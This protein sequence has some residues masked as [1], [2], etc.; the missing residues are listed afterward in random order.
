M[1]VHQLATPSQYVRL[2]QDDSQEVDVLFKELL[3][4]VTSF[5]RDPQAFEAL[6][7]GPLIQLLESRDEGSTVRAWVP[8]CA[9]GEE[10]LSVAIMLRECAAKL[11]KHFDFHLFGTDLDSEAI[12][13]ARA[14]LYPASIAA[15]VS[16]ARLERYFHREDAGYRVRREIRDMVVFAPQN[17]ISDPPFTRLDVISCR[18]LLIYLD[19]DVQQRVMANFHYA[20]NPGGILFLGTSESI[21]K[22]ADG[23]ETVDVKWKIFRR[24]QNGP[25]A[26]A[27]AHALFGGARENV[28]SPVDLTTPKS[29]KDLRLSKLLE[30]A[31]LDQLCPASVVVNER[32]EILQVHGRTGAYLELPRGQAE[33]SVIDMAREGLA[34]ELAGALRAAAKENKNVVR[35]NIRVK[36]NGGESLVN[37]SVNR[38]LDPKPIRGLLIVA[39]H[40][41]GPVTAKAGSGVKARGGAE[42]DLARQLRQMK[43]THQTVLHELETT[44]EELKGANEELQSTNEELQSLNEELETSKE[45]MQS[46][47]EE[48]TTVNTELQSKIDDLSQVNDDMQNLLNSTEIAT[49][50]LDNDLNIKRFT[51]QA[52]NV[53]AV[54]DLDVGRPMSELATKLKRGNLLHECREV[55]RTLVYWEAEVEANDGTWYLARIVPYRTSKNVIDG[56]VVTFVKIDTLREAK[57]AEA[58]ARDNLSSIVETVREPLLVL[59]DSLRVIFCNRSYYHTFQT[60]AKQTQGKLI[61][62]LGTSQWDIAPLRKLLEEILPRDE[63]IDAFR[64]EAEFPKIGRRAFVLNARRLK[65]EPGLPPMILLGME[66]A[67]SEG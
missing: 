1:D 61:Y 14:G 62:E 29:G 66:E 55:L 16:P 4:R 58:L 13:A 17:V 38:I 65:R 7:A 6:A 9:R 19:D 44:N 22:F 8:G 33:L 18:N 28:D 45:E 23:F 31:L 10:A 42:S 56:L 41:A 50:F 53:V 43:D 48:L 59:D 39:F 51:E 37:V 34:H 12:D 40:P 27:R 2:L 46:L 20:L 36:T 52:R 35:D 21:G 47:N 57:K 5:F 63:A 32:G 25:A 49:V 54:R 67:G 15:D 26:H 11:G 24:L 3:I 64:V 30:R 60:D